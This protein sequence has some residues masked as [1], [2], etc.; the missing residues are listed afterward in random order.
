MTRRARKAVGRQVAFDRLLESATNEI[1]GRRMIKSQRM[2]WTW[3]TIQPFRDVRV[4]SLDRTLETLLRR[5]CL[6]LRPANDPVPIFV[7]A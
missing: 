5:H 2:R 1:M 4:V 6:G 7:A 3:W